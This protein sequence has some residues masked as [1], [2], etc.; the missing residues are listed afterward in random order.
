MIDLERLLQ[1]LGAL[2]SEKLVDG[3]LGFLQMAA[4]H[5]QPR[6]VQGHDDGEGDQA[7]H[8]VVHTHVS[9]GEDHPQCHGAVGGAVSVGRHAGI[10]PAVG[11]LDAGD[12]ED[13]V[14]Q[15]PPL[16]A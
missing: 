12:V 10:L 13:A 16:P 4:H 11:E 3:F 14:V 5:A 8:H 7:D 15:Q 2:G 1:L 9:V 6:D